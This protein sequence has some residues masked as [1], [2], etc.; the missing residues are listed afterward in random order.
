MPFYAYLFATLYVLLCIGLAFVFYK[1]GLPKPYTRKVVHILVAFVWIILYHFTKEAPVHF[2]VVCALFTVLLFVDY[3]VKLLPHMSSDSSNAPGTVYYGVAMTVMSAASLI[4]SEMYMPF[5]IAVFCT[6]FGDGF[7]GV[8]GQSIKRFNLKIY[9]QKSL[10]GSVAN[11]IMCIAVMLAFNLVYGTGLDAL[12]IISIAFFATELELVVGLGLDNIILSFGVCALT[13]AFMNYPD[14]ILGY[15]V[16]IL[17]TPL[18]LALVYKR[19]SLTPVGTLA[20]FLTDLA[21]SVAFGNLGFV[22]LIAFFGLGIVTDKYKEKRKKTG[23]NS[24]AFIKKKGR[25]AT[26]VFANGGVGIVCAILYL[27]TRNHVFLLSYVAVMAEALADTAA[28]GIGTSARVVFDPFRWRRSEP[29]LSGGIS[30]QGT[31]ASV[32]GAAVISFIAFLFG[33][34]SLTETI[35]AIGVATLGMLFDSL[36]GSLLQAKYRCPICS[37]TVEK[38][39]CCN[40]TPELISGF[41]AVNNSTVNFLSTVFTFF[42][43]L[44]AIIIF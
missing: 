9:G 43:S 36:L 14:I 41:R 34:I 6:S 7:A 23:Q 18:V 19:G 15:I 11:F 3:K 2:F 33:A 26:Q 25:N 12:A 42:V 31:A 16:P 22:I 4:V 44:T 35:F 20:A 32:V 39:I 21:V 29:G 27:V 13:F 5:G 17:L 30:L 1:L 10:L 40:R 37:H 8:V 28:S 38:P 24:V